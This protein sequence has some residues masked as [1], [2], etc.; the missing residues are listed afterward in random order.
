MQV[1]QEKSGNV[2]KGAI[3]VFKVGKQMSHPFHRLQSVKSLKLYKEKITLTSIVKGIDWCGFWGFTIL[4]TVPFFWIPAHT[5]TF[6]LPA[7]YQVMMAAALSVALGVILSLGNRSK[8]K[9]ANKNA[10]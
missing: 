2:L 1:K 5:V 9:E 6:L 10:N 3:L 4:K 8:N 7:E